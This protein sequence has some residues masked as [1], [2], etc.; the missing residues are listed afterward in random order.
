LSHAC[1]SG[2]LLPRCLQK[3]A[4]YYDVKTGTGEDQPKDKGAYLA[5][6]DG[7]IEQPEEGV[8]TI[9]PIRDIDRGMSPILGN[10]NAM[11]DRLFRLEDNWTP[12]QNHRLEPP[13]PAMPAPEDLRLRPPVLLNSVISTW[14]NAQ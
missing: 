4:A 3:R 5:P 10:L 9:M 7:L 8:T 11:P 6:V 14:Q 1:W 2:W 12:I 13:K